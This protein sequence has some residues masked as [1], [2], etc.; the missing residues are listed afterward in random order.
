MKINLY[1]GFIID[2]KKYTIEL[3]FSLT[4]WGL[5][6][7]NTKTVKLVHCGPFSLAVFDNEQIDKKLEEMMSDTFQE[8]QDDAIGSR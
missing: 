4:E 7:K 5:F 1:G 8:G 2:I 6:Y 3:G